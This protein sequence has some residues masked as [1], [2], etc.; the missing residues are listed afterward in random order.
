MALTGGCRCRAIRYTLAAEALPLT[1][2]CHCL[3]CQT[4]SSSAFTLHALIQAD[5]LSVD[6][7]LTVY[8]YQT[9][10]GF[11]S[12]HYACRTCHT[13]I[14]NTNAVLQGMAVLRAGTL[15][16][17]ASLSPGAHIWV[18]R[19]QPWITLPKGAP[20]WQENP[21]PEQ[22]AAALRSQQA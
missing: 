6:G 8:P 5:V 13:R 21:T 10:S 4:W 20:S 19:K 15:D 1:Y 16:E 18:K 17:S 3:D 22:F 12:R 14:Y 9:Q 7:D 2:A 11:E